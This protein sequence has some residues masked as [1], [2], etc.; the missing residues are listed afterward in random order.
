MFGGW[1][2]AHTGPAVPE[3]FYFGRPE[4]E[5][6]LASAMAGGGHVLLFGSTRQGKTTLLHRILRGRDFVTF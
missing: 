5:A 3:E 4:V 1:L 2:Q 6:S